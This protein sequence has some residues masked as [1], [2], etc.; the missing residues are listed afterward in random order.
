MGPLHVVLQRFGDLGKAMVNVL[1]Q[2]GPCSTV[3]HS[4]ALPLA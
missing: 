1:Q 2:N 4:Q 3:Q